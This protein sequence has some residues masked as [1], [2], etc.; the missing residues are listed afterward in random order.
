MDKVEPEQQYIPVT[1]ENRARIVRVIKKI[2]ERRKDVWFEAFLLRLHAIDIAHL[3]NFFTEEEQSRIINALPREESAEVLSE[4]E[5]VERTAILKS[6]NIEWI[7]SRLEEL[8]PDDL[9]DI[10]KELSKWEADFIIRRFDAEFSQK[11]KELLKYPEETAGALMTSNFLTVSQNATVETVIKQFRQEAEE[12]EMQDLHFIYVVDSQN[13]LLGYI[14]IRILILEKP[15]KRAKDLMKPPPVRI[16]P[17][18]DQEEVAQIFRKYDLISI[19]VVSVDN[20]LLGR[21]TIDDILEVLEEEVSEDVY[22]MFGLHKGEKFSNGIFISL[23]H[24]LPWMFINIV[25][26]ALS[27]VII[28]LYKGLIEQFVVL[29]MFM[30]MVAALGGASGNQMVAMIVRG[31]AVGQLHWKHVRWVLFRD[32]IA[33]TLGALLIGALIGAATHFLFQ[34]YTLGLV[35]GLALLLNMVFATIMGAAIPLLLRLFNLDPALGSSILVAGSTDMMGFFI[36]LWLA[37]EI[38]I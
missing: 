31:L 6:K 22:R 14:P 5:P 17:E 7:F 9:V 23:K 24:R 13:H 38:L 32:T 16:N 12:N 21:I 15:D 20:V 30:P 34:D 19:P 25:S 35:V 11:I 1:E 36:F 26:T 10:L 8:D 2:I 27:A 33:V 18:M 37:S 29:A 3:W 4:L 28:G